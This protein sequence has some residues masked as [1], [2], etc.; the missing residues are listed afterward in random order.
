MGICSK[1]GDKPYNLKAR[2]IQIFTQTVKKTSTCRLECI[3]GSI[4]GILSIFGP[5]DALNKMLSNSLYRRLLFEITSLD[6]W[7]KN[8]VK[9]FALL[10][11][12][13]VLASIISHIYECQNTLI[14]KNKGLISRI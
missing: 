4:L 13:S 11:L 3:Y 6:L 5:E 8:E 9:H 1:F 10:S 2:I 7:K 12:L 14:R